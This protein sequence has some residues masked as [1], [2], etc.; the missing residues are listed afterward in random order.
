MLRRSLEMRH[1]MQT[2]SES[3]SRL[4]TALHPHMNEDEAN[5]H[6]NSTHAP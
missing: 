2:E 4:T 3:G 6:A 1:I 5:C